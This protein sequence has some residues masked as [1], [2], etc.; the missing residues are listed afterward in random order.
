MFDLLV[1]EQGANAAV[2]LACTAPTGRPGAALVHAFGGRPLVLSEGIW[3]AHLSRLAGASQRTWPASSDLARQLRP[4]PGHKRHDATPATN[5]ARRSGCAVDRALLLRGPIDGQQNVPRRL[6]AGDRHQHVTR[7]SRQEV[8]HVE[9]SR[10]LE[11]AGDTLLE[12][13]AAISSASAWLR[14]QATRTGSP[15]A[16]WGLIL[17]ARS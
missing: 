11:Q 8:G 6:C 1:S 12:Q 10:S 15:S 17:R 5:P 4:Q 7:A 9:A 13:H 16:Y 2:T 14:A 3:R